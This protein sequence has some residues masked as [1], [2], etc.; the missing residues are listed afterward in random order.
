M[1]YKIF[2]MVPI[3]LFL[4][5]AGVLV[6]NYLQTGEWFHRSIELTGGAM[7]TLN[8]QQQPDIGKIKDALGSEFGSIDVRELR[9]FT[10]YGLTISAGAG[11]DT[12]AIL[13]K[14]GSI[15]INTA[16]YSVATIGPALGSNFWAQAQLAM[17]LAFVFMAIVVFVMFRIFLPSSYVIG[18]A[19][20][21]IIV[22]LGF[23]QIFGIEL[24]LTTLAAVLMLIGYSVDTD[25]LLTTRFLKN[26]G[27]M[28]E[29]FIGALKTGLTMTFTTIGA[30]AAITI[31]A[32]SPVLTQIASVLLIG[33]SADIINTWMMNYVILRW[34]IERTGVRNA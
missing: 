4:L 7:I 22:T 9:G 20:A 29:K 24:S 2:L 5:S 34:H 33:L 13:N 32:P 12:Q 15:G 31:T 21:D 19:A 27:E 8:L 16:D 3:A 10:G 30:V 25:I 18:C 14:L 17:L 1:N 11:A 6:N 23:M 28:K 26:A